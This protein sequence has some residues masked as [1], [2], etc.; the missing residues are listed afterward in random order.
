MGSDLWTYRT[1]M[2]GMSATDEL[3]GFKVDARDGS[4]GKIDEATGETG[5]SSVV[6]DTGP[7]E[8]RVST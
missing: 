5:R 2:T 6:V 1:G 3:E 4:I 8:S 7:I